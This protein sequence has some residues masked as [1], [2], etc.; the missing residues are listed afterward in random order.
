MTAAGGFFASAEPG[1][2]TNLAV[3]EPRYSADTRLLAPV[4]VAVPVAGF[5]PFRPEAS[6]SCRMPMCDNS[7]AS[8]ARWMPSGFTCGAPGLMP[9]GLA[10]E[11]SWR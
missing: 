1:K 3:R 5:A 7:P 11:V 10:I 6:L 8:N 9:I 2:G 4:L